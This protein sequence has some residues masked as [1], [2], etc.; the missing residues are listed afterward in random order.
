[1]LI[2]YLVLRFH[3][4][5]RAEI[6]ARMM[7]G[8]IVNE[9]GNPLG[10]DTPFS[11]HMS[12]FYYRTV[13]SETRIPFEETILHQDEELVVADKP[14]FL[15]VTPTGRYLQETLLVRLIRRLDLPHLT[16]IHRLDRD[17]AGVILFSVNPRNRRIYQDLFRRRAVLKTYEAIAP[18]R[19]DLSLPVLRKSRLVTGTPFMRMREAAHESPDDVNAQTHIELLE[20]DSASGLARYGLRP[21]TGKKHQLRVHMA[22][23]GIPILNDPLYP[24]AMPPSSDS[25]A[26][27]SAPLQLLASTM[28]F[29]DP[30]IGTQR[31]FRSLRQLR[32][33]AQPTRG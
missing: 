6:I 27:Y 16:P 25:A 32:W 9:V 10:P 17:T 31:I 18:Y 7:R 20:H 29:T 2:D 33:P 13:E 22:A 28:A 14:H 19:S 4:I 23:L 30:V 21:I 3:P 8:E 15:P 5:Q 24:T 12:V 1:M 26:D 11:R